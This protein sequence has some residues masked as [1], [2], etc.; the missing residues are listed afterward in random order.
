M[1]FFDFS[2]I[3]FVCQVPSIF[4]VVTGNICVTAAESTGYGL[5]IMTRTAAFRFCFFLAPFHWYS[6]AES[7]QSDSKN[8]E[9]FL[10]LSL[11]ELVILRVFV[12]KE[13]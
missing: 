2:M 8:M 10:A 1:K 3:F 6:F 4:A 12:I 9:N 13:L 11:P 7:R 5:L